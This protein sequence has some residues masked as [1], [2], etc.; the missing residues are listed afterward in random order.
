MATGN[1]PLAL[2]RIKEVRRLF[3]RGDAWMHYYTVD[4]P[5]SPVLDLLNVRY[6]LHWETSPGAT[7]PGH[8]LRENADALPRF[9]LVNQTVTAGRLDALDL[10]NEALVEGDSAVW[11]NP[12][13]ARGTVT[14][15]LYGSSRLRLRTTVPAGG[16]FLVTSDAYYPGWQAEID[17]RAAEVVLTNR[18]FRGLRL[19]PGEHVVTMRFR[20]WILAWGAAVSALALGFQAARS[21]QW[22]TKPRQVNH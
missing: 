11:E 10:R 12:G 7:L 9:F 18:A 22:H 13:A 6:L 20:P 15:E 16:S 4:K 3:A 19:P 17:G 14:V 8:E 2:A 21:R 5:E 1:D